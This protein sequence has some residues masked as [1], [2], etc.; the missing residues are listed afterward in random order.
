MQY[1]RTNLDK[2]VKIQS[3]FR[4]KEQREQYRQLTIGSNVSVGT[5]K[6][7]VHLLD[8]SEADFGEE[9][10]VERLRKR[11]VEGIRENQSLESDVNELDVKIALVV[12]NVKSFE[13]LIR[14]KRRHGGDSAAAHAARA[15]VLAAHGDPFAGPNTLDQ[16]TKRKLELYQQLF[17]LLQVKT[18]YLGKLF[19]RLSNTE[20]SESVQR[21]AERVV[22][23]IF[24]YGQDQREEYLLLKLFQHSIHQ[25]ILSAASPIDVLRT[26]TMHLSVT[27]HYVRPK[28]VAYVRDALQQAILEVINQPDLDLET[29]PLALYRQRI[30]EEEMRTGKQSSKPRDLPFFL[31]AQ[32]LEV[33]T[34]LIWNLQRLQAFTNTFVD[35][36]TFST[37]RMPYGMRCLA[38]ELLG[39]LKD[40]FPHEPE[41]V[42]AMIVGRLVY[43]RYI[44]PAI[45]APETFD[46]V[47]TT[48]ST[49]SRKNLAQISTMLTQIARGTLFGA[50]DPALQA[51]NEFIARSISK[52]SRW[53]F[54]VTDVPDAEAQFHAHEFLDVTVQPK[55][56]YISPNEVYA[57]HSLLA[58]HVDHIVTG[59]NDPLRTILTE[60]DGVPQFGSDE[61]KDARDRAI[62]LELTN[63]FAEVEDPH[64][65]EKALWVQAKRG[66]L[67]ILRVQP[68]TDLVEALVQPPTEEQEILWESIVENEMATDRMRERQRRM[69]STAGGDS[70]YRLEDIRALSFKD[71]KGQAIYF[72]LEL[73]KR[74]KVTRADGY[75]G[76]LNAIAADVRSK[77]RK[78]LQRQKEMQTM[79]E[80]L[81]HLA[82]R[83]R[84]FEEQINQYNNYV[85]SAMETMQRGN[86]KRRFVMPFSKQFFHLRDLHRNG[87]IPQFGSYKYSAQDLYDRGILLSIDQYSPKQFDRIDVILSSNQIGVFRIQATNTTVGALIGTEDLKMEDLLQ[88]QYANRASLAVLGGKA[89]FNLDLLL[90]Q[91]NKKFYV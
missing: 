87:T 26:N 43:Y 18:D 82:E 73:E 49:T 44:N 6:N 57:M 12:Q 10:E 4:A 32:D 91:I 72:L 45:V 40:K 13:D 88:S 38:K 69:P 61:L 15:S 65:D 55:P 36:I 74:G 85:K 62:T 22:L 25:E 5:I 3:L 67:A 2:V 63:R 75:Q 84:H 90:Y 30:D 52:F 42:Y 54:E 70:A 28:Q 35:A 29:D 76:I 14:A 7:F 1:Y 79:T 27:V 53:F 83:K 60:L 59:R 20:I 81:R 50:E 16:A 8:D 33:R 21:T 89:K 41:E 24:G 11:V 23:T 9:I 31:A 46:I 37:R 71:V 51:T 66:V 64:A 68:A 78:R 39:S 56:I 48:V 86:G 47:S 58:Q 77:H 34:K 19:F 80:V 17:Y